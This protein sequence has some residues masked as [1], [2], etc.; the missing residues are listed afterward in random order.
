MWAHDTQFEVRVKNNFFFI[1]HLYIDSIN[2]KVCR[3]YNNRTSGTVLYM[4]EK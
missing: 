2:N 4:S 1:F 3:V